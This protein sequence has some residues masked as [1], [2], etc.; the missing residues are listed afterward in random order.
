M[1]TADPNV[2][3]AHAKYVREKLDEKGFSETEHMLNEWNRMYADVPENYE[4]MRNH[5]GASFCAQSFAVMQESS[6]EKAMYYD[7][8]PMRRYCGLYDFPGYRPTKTYYSFYAFNRL[9]RLGGCVGVKVFEG[10]QVSAMAATNGTEKAIMLANYSDKE[11]HILIDL[12][13][14]GCETEFAVWVIDENRTYEKH[15]LVWPSESGKLS[16]FLQ[17]FSVMLLEQTK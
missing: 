13:G 8:Y 10:E 14:V 4:E 11:Q 2:I 6:I 3:A 9:Y 7:A 1:D 5:K 16:F 17:P 12:E 15:S